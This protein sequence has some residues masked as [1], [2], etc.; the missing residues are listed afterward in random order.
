MEN[1]RD[2]TDGIKANSNRKCAEVSQ[3][4]S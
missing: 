3:K 4:W 2:I 1:I